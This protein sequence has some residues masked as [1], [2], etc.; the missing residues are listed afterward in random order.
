[1][2]EYLELKSG[3]LI[4]PAIVRQNSGRSLTDQH[5]LLLCSQVDKAAVRDGLNDE[6][7]LVWNLM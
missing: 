3:Q 6:R 1:M 7:R 2:A 5:D 4:R